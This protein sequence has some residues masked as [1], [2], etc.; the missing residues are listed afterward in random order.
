MNEKLKKALDYLCVVNNVSA[1]MLSH[2]LDE[3]RTK[4]MF[5]FLHSIGVELE[6]QAIRRWAVEKKWEKVSVKE[7]TDLAHKISSGKRVVINYPG[8]LGDKILSE[9]KSM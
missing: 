6:Q 4:E 1:G 7:L 8:R 5:K 9:L 2:P 3:S